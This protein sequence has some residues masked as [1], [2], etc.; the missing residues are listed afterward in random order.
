MWLFENVE[1]LEI[2][3]DAYGYVY[4]ITNKITGRMYI[5]KKLFWFR[6]Q[7]TNKGKRKIIKVVS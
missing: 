3:S 7:K 5:G 2:P 4:L 6:K 1:L